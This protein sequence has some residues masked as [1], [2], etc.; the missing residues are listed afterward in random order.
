VRGEK[1]KVEEKRKEFNAEGAET[2]RTQRRERRREERPASEG[3]PYK[4]Y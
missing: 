3:G 4:G 2:Q 1:L